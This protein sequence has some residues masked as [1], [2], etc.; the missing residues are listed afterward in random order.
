MVLRNGHEQ[1]FVPKRIL[2]SLKQETG[3][4]HEKAMKVL[5]AI[6]RDYIATNQEKVT[7]PMIR[8]KACVTMYE[9]GFKKERH[10]YTR[11]GFPMYDLR[12]ILD[13]DMP[14]DVKMRLVYNHV[15]QEYEAVKKLIE[16]CDDE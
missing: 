3:L 8:E 6:R 9:M 13:V 5:E 7:P 15:K 10:Y 14:E 11:I 12:F 2:I 16:R 1:E 4:E